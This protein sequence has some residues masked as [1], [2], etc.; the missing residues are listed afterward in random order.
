MYYFD[1]ADYQGS[2]RGLTDE[3]KKN[4]VIEILEINHRQNTSYK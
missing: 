4:G 3:I 1:L 2:C